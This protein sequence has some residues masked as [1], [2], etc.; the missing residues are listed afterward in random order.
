MGALTKFKTMSHWFGDALFTIDRD[1]IFSFIPN[2]YKNITTPIS[3]HF[4]WK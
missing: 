1:E 4:G 2:P 3:S